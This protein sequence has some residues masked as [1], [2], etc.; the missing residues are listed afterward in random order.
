M[1]GTMA[2]KPY[3][4]NSF[5]DHMVE[6]FAGTHDSSLSETIVYFLRPAVNA[7]AVA[8]VSSMSV[9]SPAMKARWVTA[10]GKAVLPTAQHASKPRAI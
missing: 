7:S 8:E 9:P 10:A 3:A 1:E 6:S 2:G 5:W 4:P